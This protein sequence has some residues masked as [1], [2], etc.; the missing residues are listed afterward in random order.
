MGGGGLDDV[1][2]AAEPL[3]DLPA[4]NTIGEDL[5]LD[6]RADATFFG[7][8]VEFT[9][10]LAD[11]AE[12]FSD[13]THLP[14]GRRVLDSAGSSVEA[15]PDDFEAAVAGLLVAE[16]DGLTFRDDCSPSALKPVF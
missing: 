10:L 13:G 15:L 6:S 11:R 4:M 3:S 2:S 8:A 16:L 9:D 14:A 1:V 5:R 12:L 7:G